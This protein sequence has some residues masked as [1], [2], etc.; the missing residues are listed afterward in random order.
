MG[1][2]QAPIRMVTGFFRGVVK[3]PERELATDTH[4]NMRLRMS[5]PVIFRRINDNEISLNFRYMCRIL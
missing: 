4:M 2:G 5:G 3:R 1:L